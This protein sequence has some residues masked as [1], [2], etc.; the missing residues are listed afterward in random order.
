MLSNN[1]HQGDAIGKSTPLSSG[2][3]DNNNNQSPRLEQQ[4]KEESEVR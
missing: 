1:H 2:S 3:N 4:I